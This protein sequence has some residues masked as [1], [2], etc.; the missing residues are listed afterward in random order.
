VLISEVT[1]ES[2]SA[3]THRRHTKLSVVV[4]AFNEGTRL[5]TGLPQL[6]DVVG[7]ET[8]VIVVDD[9]STDGTAD[10]ARRHLA[11]LPRSVVMRLPK[12]SGKGAAVRAGVVKAGGDVIAYLDADMATD[13]HDLLRLVEALDESEVVVGSRAQPDSVIEHWSPHRRL[14]TRTFSLFVTSTLN[15]PMRDTQCGFKAFHGS[16]AKLLFHGCR[17]DGFAFDLEI[18][19][20]AA[21]LGLHMEEVPVHWNEMP[22]SK[23]RVIHD[24]LNMLLDVSKTSRGHR[25]EPPIQGVVALN[26]DPLATA[27]LFRS[28]VRPTD[29]VL[30]W[31]EGAAVLFP[32]APPTASARMAHELETALPSCQ[33]QRIE[34]DFEALCSRPAPSDDDRSCTATSEAPFPSGSRHRGHGGVGSTTVDDDKLHSKSGSRWDRW[35]WNGPGEAPWRLRRSSGRSRPRLPTAPGEPPWNG[36]P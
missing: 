12:N 11:G 29:T 21:R 36:A 33:L 22:G 20:R 26:G 30:A 19:A 2:G 1:R 18:L 25:E 16:V 7:Q 23:V 24:S 5:A 35:H 27:H 10:V 32:C 8:E 31:D 3:P 9:G 34:L 17:V 13:P 15:L 14:M 28:T 6:L 4:P